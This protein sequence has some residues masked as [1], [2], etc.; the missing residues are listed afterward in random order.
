ME[1]KYKRLL[2]IL[3]LTLLTIM[4]ITLLLGLDSTVPYKLEAILGWIAA[5]SNGALANIERKW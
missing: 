3:P 5:T 1:K 2:W 4:I